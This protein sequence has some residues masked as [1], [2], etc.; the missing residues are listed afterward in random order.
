MRGSIAIAAVVCPILL[1][2]SSRSRFGRCSPPEGERQV[3]DEE[4]E[5][6]EEKEEE[7]DEDEEEGEGGG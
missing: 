3:D 2:R 4:E 5:G 6:E 1:T 7:G